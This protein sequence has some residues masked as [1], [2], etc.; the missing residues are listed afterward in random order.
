MKLNKLL[1]LSGNDIPFP[2]GQTIIHVPKIKEIA[3][4]GEKAFF[5]GSNFLCFSKE[6]LKEQ[7]KINLKNFTDFDILMSKLNHKVDDSMEIIINS[8][9]FILSL[10][11]PNYDLVK[12]PN[13]ILLN[14]IDQDTGKKEQIRINNDNFEQFREIVKSMF[15]LQLSNESQYNPANKKAAQIAK[16]L[17][18]RKRKLQKHNESK[19]QEINI[20]YRYISILALGNHH[21]I[22]QLMDYTVYQLFDEFQRFQKKYSYDIWL[23]AKMAG[24]QN[25][26]DADSWLNDE[27]KK[28][29]SLPK[30]NRIEF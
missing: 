28:V 14:K 17:Q 3:L 19:D 16:K 4:I 29:E 26:D 15:C 9:I 21:T 30:S 18:D 7:D 12:M 1:L 13:M 2:G 11:F 23:Q 5:L 6:K 10:L 20:F 22:P 24:A 25:L 8:V 27:Q